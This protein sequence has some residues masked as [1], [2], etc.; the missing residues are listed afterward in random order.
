MPSNQT[1][2]LKNWKTYEEQLDILKS[3]GLQIGDEKKALGYLRTIGYYRLSGYLYPFRQIDPKNS[4]RRLDDFIVDSHFEDVKSLYMFDKKLRQLA[5]DALE[6]IEIALRVNIAY[7]LGQYSPLAHRDQQYFN[8]GSNCLAWVE[9]YNRLIERESKNSFV[10]HHLDHY[11]DL[12]IWV[13]CEIWDFGTMSMLYKGMK[14]GDKNKIA[15]M[16]R[17]QDGKHLQTHLHAFN[18]IRNVSAHHSRLWNRDITIK[19][20]LKGLRD[21]EWQSLPVNRVFVYFCLMKRMLDII[22]PNSSWGHRFL[23]VLGEFPQVEN[24]AVTLEQMGMTI[25]PKEWLLWQ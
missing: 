11:G 19:A 25:K 21:P 6:R 3:R 15:N 1:K 10:K 8:S 9:K 5:L 12:P 20:S 2:A 23:E 18:L 14:I 16:Y 22:C 4:K 13:A 7:T 17:L 24:Q